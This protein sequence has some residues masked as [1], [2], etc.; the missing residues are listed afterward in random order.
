MAAKRLAERFEAIRV[1]DEDFELADPAPFSHTAPVTTVA[2]SGWATFFGSCGSDEIFEF[3]GGCAA[4]NATKV[5]QLDTYNDLLL[6]VET[7]KGNSVLVNTN[8]NQRN[9]GSLREQ[10]F[11]DK[12]SFSELHESCIDKVNSSDGFMEVHGH[13]R[14]EEKFEITVP[15]SAEKVEPIPGHRHITNYFLPMG[16]DNQELN[17]LSCS[18][19]SSPKSSDGKCIVL[20]SHNSIE[21][22][23]N[24]PEFE[25]CR[26]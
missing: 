8:V 6:E 3:H 11:N 15:Y 19:T 24:K 22:H 9:E 23:I 21:V 26:D 12:S 25:K 16:A 10:P 7:G 5:S 13:H 14:L 4:P 1:D 2:E 18:S 20:S 17:L